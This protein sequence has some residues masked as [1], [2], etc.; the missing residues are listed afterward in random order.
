MS[1]TVGHLAKLTGLTVRALHHYDAIGLLTPSQRSDS[2]YRLYTQADIIKLYRIQALQRFGLS[3]TEIETALAREG[4]TLPEMI[5]QQLAALDTQIEQATTL[6]LRLQHLREV[7]ARGDE[8]GTGEWLSAV[9]LITQYDKYCSPEELQR[10]LENNN[11]DLPKWRA[12]I[13]DIRISMD[14][15]V[16]PQDNQAQDLLKR[17]SALAMR[18]VRGDVNLMVKMKLAYAKDAGIQSRMA[19]Q[20]G[21]S[22][23]LGEYLAQIMTH[24]HLAL[25]SRYLT[26]EE[27]RRLSPQ[28]AWQQKLIHVVGALRQENERQYGT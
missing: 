13:D 17:W 25:W 19:V 2:G 1:F 18:K 28:G 5:S 15:N 10:L 22:P 16:A 6:R 27:V 9:E 7:L 23:Q 8:P 11:D 4:A 26:K 21:L 20:S 24:A 3:L 14:S 12:L